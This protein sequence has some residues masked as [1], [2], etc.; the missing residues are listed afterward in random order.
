MTS[1]KLSESRLLFFPSSPILRRYLRFP[2]Q[3]EQHFA[4]QHAT[5]VSADGTENEDLSATAE[6]NWSAVRVESGIA[7]RRRG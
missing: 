7:L 6:S 5:I 1:A 4:H 3:K 2:T